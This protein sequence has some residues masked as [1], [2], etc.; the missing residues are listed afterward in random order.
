MNKGLALGI[1][2][3]FILVISNI[4]ALFP[5][6][7]PRYYL[8]ISIIIMGLS[9][10]VMYSFYSG[11]LEAKL[12]NVRRIV[13]DNKTGKIIFVLNKSD[14]FSYE[15]IVSIFYYDHNNEIEIFLGVGYVETIT[16]KK[17]LQIVM[18]KWMI[19]EMVNDVR[20]RILGGQSIERSIMIKPSVPRMWLGGQ[21]N[22]KI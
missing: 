18:L 5:E 22:G 9:L 2:T 14:L 4:S 11:R 15:S 17:M 21:E 1:T 8:N 3:V 12:P 16:Q 20:Q 13:R 6:A 19:D 10:L 7:V